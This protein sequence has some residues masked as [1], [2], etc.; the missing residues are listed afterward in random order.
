MNIRKMILATVMIGLATVAA[1]VAQ[2]LRHRA[3]QKNDKLVQE[4]DLDLREK[5]KMLFEKGSLKVADD[6][7]GSN[8][9][10]QIYMGD[11][12]FPY[13]EADIFNSSGS[14]QTRILDINVNIDT[15]VSLIR[16]NT[17]EISYALTFFSEDEDQKI[18]MLFD[19]NMDGQWDMRDNPTRSE[20]RSL[21]YL[22]GEWLSVDKNENRLSDLPV[23][24][25]NDVRYE[26]RN[27]KWSEAKSAS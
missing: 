4:R 23:A 5:G 10:Y 21:I 25:K 16:K 3:T 24:W 19:L 22:N 17:K 20:S 14:E 18:F 26:F 8:Y 9:L 6:S 13:F 1:L 27:G 11:S 12:Y 2:D 7:S 15:S